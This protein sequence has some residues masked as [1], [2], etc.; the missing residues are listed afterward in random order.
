MGNDLPQMNKICLI[1]QPAGLGDIFFTQKIAQTILKKGLATEII[2][3]VIKEYT[4]LSNYLVS[5]NVTFVDE[6]ESFPFKEFYA[7][8][9]KNVH[10]GSELL[11]IPLQHADKHVPTSPI[12]Q[13][14]YAFVDGLP[15]SDWKDY[16]VFKRYLDRELKLINYL[17][18]DLEEPFNLIN[19]KFGSKNYAHLNNSV[20]ISVTNG[21]KNIEM[22]YLDFDNVFDWLTLMERAVEIHTVDTAWCYI[23]E[24]LGRG[25]VTVYSRLKNEAFFRYVNGIFNPNWKFI[26]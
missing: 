15:Y 8:D 5:K 1:K 19:R 14:K 21:F 6:N 18:I 10:N 2:W 26:L 16:F 9:H 4:Y 22:D 20:S 7:A 24:K 11:Y 25:N 13:A 23:L 3:P 17:G 12:M